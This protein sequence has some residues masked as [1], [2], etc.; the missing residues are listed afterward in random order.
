MWRTQALN[1]DFWLRLAVAALT[2]VGIWTV[3][4]PDQVFGRF[5]N[6]V[7]HKLP[8]W[9]CK[10]LFICPPCMSSVHGTWVW[11]ALGGDALYWPL[12]VICLCGAMRLISENLLK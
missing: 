6:W 2:I 5:T 3:C 11:F 1:P 12:F 8:K 9:V 7:E 4:E 10:P